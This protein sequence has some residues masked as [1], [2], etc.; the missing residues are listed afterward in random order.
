[1]Y[2]KQNTEKRQ[3]PNGKAPA[4]EI[5][6]EQEAAEKLLDIGNEAMGQMDALPNLI[7]NEANLGIADDSL[8]HYKEND[9]RDMIPKEIIQNPLEHYL[10]NDLKKQN[11]DNPI[12]KKRKNKKKE[13]N[14]NLIN[15]KPLIEDMAENNQSFDMDFEES[16][17]LITNKPVREGMAENDQSFDMDFEESNNLINNKPVR[18]G[19][20]E[21]DYPDDENQPLIREEPEKL[22]TEIINENKPGSAGKKGKESAKP[23]QKSK[24]A[25]NA[26][27]AAPQQD[28]DLTQFDESMAPA[29][30]WD[31]T[32]QKFPARKKQNFLSKIGSWAA[33]Y[34]GKTFGKILGI[35]ATIGKSIYDFF[36]PGPGTFKGSVNRLRG[37]SRFKERN[38]T[39]LIPG[40]DG[41]KFENEEG[42]A[43]VVNA[44]FRRVPEI[45]SW[46]I[47]A[48]ATEGKDEDRNAKPLDPVISIYIGQGDKDYTV[49]KNNATGHSGIGVEFSRYS[50]LSG[51][52]QRYNLR[53]GYYMASGGSA[54]SKFAVTSYNNATIPGRLADE[55]GKQYDISR[56]FAA[57][58]KQVSDVLRAAESYADRG[59]YNGYTRNCTTFAKEMIVDVAKIKGASAAF[60]KDDV[61]LP[62]KA[63]AQMFAA[64]MLAPITKADMENAYDK[65]SQKDDLSYQRFGDKMISKEEYERYK[66]SLSLWTWRQDEAD[67]PNA[68]AEN[69]RRTEGGTSGTIGMFKSVANGSK[70]L[71]EAPMSVVLKQLPSVFA[72]IKTT[73][74]IVTPVDKLA[75]AEM[76]DLLKD[77]T[78][79]DI[80]EQLQEWMGN[81]TDDNLMMT[82]TKQSD[83]VKMRNLM[84][85]TIKKL[86]ILLFKYYR[87]DKRVQKAVLPAISLLNH[88]IN[89]VDNAYVQT[90]NKDLT[91]RNGE[92]SDI[93]KDFS[94]LNTTEKALT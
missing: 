4:I 62:V 92:L 22:I 6:E 56:S 66:N 7:S 84:T 8:A 94:N 85:D 34:S 42:P 63:D 90:D 43:D 69:L 30:G 60:A 46:P 16:N 24:K 11:L 87:N 41:E 12:K 2:R 26:I 49:G 19:M 88:G 15:N 77:L 73:L 80:A 36:R 23:S 79:Q 61:H 78:G 38:D 35:F 67:S 54:E 71:E 53:F 14:L 40:W 64:G 58:P 44:D 50:A 48:K 18:E 89:F 27:A 28:E 20:A 68:V 72:D 57:K 82:K 1:M 70:R 3:K 5:R 17:N 76:K 21:K 47:A 51:R 74:S 37:S 65:N 55:R 45:W 86:N 33:Y 59:G 83:L 75:A 32:A 13:E 91:D 25:S 9:I 52:W 81:E 31:F 29:Q 39:D 93:Q 10:N